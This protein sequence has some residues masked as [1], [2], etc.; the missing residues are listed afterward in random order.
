[1]N[2][3]YTTVGECLSSLFDMEMTSLIQRA[4]NDYRNTNR[5]YGNI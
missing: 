4:K 1:M 3:T 2:C 5:C